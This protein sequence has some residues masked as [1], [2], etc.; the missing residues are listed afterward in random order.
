M[1]KIKKLQKEIKEL[2]IRLWKLENPPEFKYGDTVKFK[3]F[4]S[5]GDN[6]FVGIVKSSRHRYDYNDPYYSYWDYTIDTGEHLTEADTYNSSIKK[7]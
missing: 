3:L 7:A 6:W 5:E 1:R 4:S 2:S